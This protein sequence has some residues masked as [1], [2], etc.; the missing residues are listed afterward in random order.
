VR[1]VLRSPLEPVAIEWD[2]VQLHVVFE[3][4]E[5]AVDA[6]SAALVS[7]AG[8]GDVSEALPPD[9][10]ARPWQPGDVAVKVTHRL[11]A[12]SAVLDDVRRHLPGCRVTAHAGSGV[13]HA[14]VSAG[15]I[16]V[17]PT[18]ERLRADIAA[19]GGSVVVVDAPDDIKSSLDV[20]GPVRGL[21]VM[22]RVKDQFDRDGRMSPGRFV[23]GI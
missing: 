1:D 4:V 8:S 15:A 13:V 16:D 23:G 12:L 2:D 22:L 9:L 3:S 7:L 10:G 5:A 11:S 20:W 21:D 6:Q 14:G 17:A 19:Y 18:V